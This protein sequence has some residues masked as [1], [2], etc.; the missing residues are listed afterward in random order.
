M[1][2][3]GRGSH[4]TG[5][6][7][8]AAL[9]GRPCLGASPSRMPRLACRLV[10]RAPVPGNH[11][12]VVVLICV[13]PPA[14]ADGSGVQTRPLRLPAGL[15][16]RVGP[17]GPAIQ[18]LRAAQVQERLVPKHGRMAAANRAHLR[19]AFRRL[20]AREGAGASCR[21]K[22]GWVRSLAA[23]LPIRTGP[24]KRH[25][26]WPRLVFAPLVIF[27]LRLAKAPLLIAPLD[28]HPV[29]LVGECV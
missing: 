28:A 16:F 18:I 24:D 4:A 8:V 17:C 6:R 1:R 21:R 13:H 25:S 12:S 27:A 22:W 9:A 2:G 14:H 29:A 3:R 15:R 10:A 11:A 23:A 20:A 7:R 19:I 5:K 26:P